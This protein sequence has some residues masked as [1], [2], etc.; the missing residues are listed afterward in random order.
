MANWRNN[1]PHPHVNQ[2]DLTHAQL[3]ARIADKTSRPADIDA[4]QAA[5]SV[6]EDDDENDDG[7]DDD[8]HAVRRLLRWW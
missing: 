8:R 1:I 4:A 5:A 2:A 6:Y 7:A 3:T